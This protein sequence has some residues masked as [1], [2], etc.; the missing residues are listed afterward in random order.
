MQP[1]TTS[2]LLEEE[3]KKAIG[4]LGAEETNISA[5]LSKLELKPLE[6]MLFKRYKTWTGDQRLKYQ[7]MSMIKAIV[8]KELCGFRS[9]G[10][11]IDHLCHNPVDTENLGFDKLVPSEQSFSHM[12]KERIDNDIE[13]V[14]KFVCDKIADISREQKRCFNIAFSVEKDFRGESKRTIARQKVKEGT[15]IIR[16]LREEIFPTLQL[17]LETTARYCKDNFLDLIAYVAYNHVC[18]NQGY[19]LMREEGKEAVPHARTMLGYLSKLTAEEIME[20]FIASFDRIFIMARNRGLLSGPVDLALDFHDWLYYGDKNDEMVVEG[21]PKLGTCHRF[22]FAVL[23]IAEKYGDFTLLAL[24]VGIFSND[25][26]VVKTLLEFAKK[27]V[28]V[29][30]LYADRGFYASKYI[31][32]FEEMGMKY[33]MPGVKN[34]RVVRLMKTH[35]APVAID[36]KICNYAG[37]CVDTK[38]VIRTAQDGRDVAFATNLPPMLLYGGNLFALYSKRWNIETGFRVQKHEFR[39]CTTSKN[40]KVRMFYFMFSELLYNIWVILNA[41]LSVYLFGEQV[42]YRVMTA[43]MFM[44]KFYEAYQEHTSE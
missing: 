27:R 30:Y 19:E 18:A 9:Y 23:K 16:Y 32:L 24:P 41:F 7:P 15:K 35:K 21:E 31:S 38:I 42:D 10:C 34:K 6:D 11:L 8:F 36:I 20:M 1:T 29:R 33:L 26:E 2:I 13:D 25:R 12:L 43:K 14:M 5:L 4:Q 44:K 17:P 22:R 37:K 40:Y 28:N 39:A 3:I